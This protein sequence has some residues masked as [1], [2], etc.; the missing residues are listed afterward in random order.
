MTVSSFRVVKKIPFLRE[1]LVRNRLNVISVSFY[2][3]HLAYNRVCFSEHIYNRDSKHFHL[4]FLQLRPS[5]KPIS[6]VIYVVGRK[7]AAFSRRDLKVI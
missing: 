6:N 1:V 4:I 5:L 7:K 2:N 3:T